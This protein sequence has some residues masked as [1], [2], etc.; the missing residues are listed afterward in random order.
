MHSFWSVHRDSNLLTDQCVFEAS[1][2]P[3]VIYHNIRVILQL[4]LLQFFPCIPLF[5]TKLHYH[6][7]GLFLTNMFVLLM[8]RIAR[9]MHYI[10]NYWVSENRLYIYIYICIHLRGRERDR[11]SEEERERVRAWDLVCVPVWLGIIEEDV[12]SL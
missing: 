6:T 2:L 5:Y 4:S 12:S 1:V 3:N 8:Y 9:C 11:R 10:Y 7:Y